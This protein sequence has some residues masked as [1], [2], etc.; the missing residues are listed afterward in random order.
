MKMKTLALV[1]CMLSLQ[2]GLLGQEKGDTLTKA[3]SIIL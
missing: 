2:A 1:I 3:K